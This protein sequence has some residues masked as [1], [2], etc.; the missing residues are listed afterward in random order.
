VIAAVVVVLHNA[1]IGHL[2]VAGH[3]I[4]DLVHFVLD[5]APVSRKTDKP[6]WSVIHVGSY[7]LLHSRNSLAAGKTPA[8]SGRLSLFQRL[9]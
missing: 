2:Q 6:R 5:T 4:R 1:G 3:F 8:S 9:E 7:R